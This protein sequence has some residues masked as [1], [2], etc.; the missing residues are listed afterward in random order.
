MKQITCI[1]AE[2][3]DAPRISCSL[4]L[5][6]WEVDKFADLDTLVKHL[7]DELKAIWMYGNGQSVAAAT[8]PRKEMI[9]YFWSKRPTSITISFKDGTKSVYGIDYPKDAKNFPNISHQLPR[10]W[11]KNS[12]KKVRN[13]ERADRT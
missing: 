8:M 11:N 4:D 13:N 3:A 9:K 5:N 6:A 2:H 1:Y 7:I 10:G 12:T